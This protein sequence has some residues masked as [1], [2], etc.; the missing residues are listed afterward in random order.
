M[1]VAGNANH[2]DGALLPG[3][4][5]TDIHPAHIVHDGHQGRVFALVGV[6]NPLQVIVVAEVPGAVLFPGVLVALGQLLAQLHDIH[7]GVAVCP[8]NLFH[9]IQ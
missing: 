2:V 4:Q 3:L 9:E 6:D 8:P 5:V 7:C 1:H